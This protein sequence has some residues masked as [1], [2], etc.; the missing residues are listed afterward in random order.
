MR[1]PSGVDSRRDI[2]E[3]PPD[4]LPE[5]VAFLRTN[6]ARTNLTALAAFM[7]VSVS[8]V[9]KWESPS[10]EKYPRGAAARLLQIVES[11]GVDGL[12]S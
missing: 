6:I 1:R 5:R 11:K 3:R 10:A 7:N 4:L 8:T 12:V 2:F 9:R